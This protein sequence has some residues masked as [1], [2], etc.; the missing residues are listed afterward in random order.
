MTREVLAGLVGKS[1]SWLKAV[2]H[3][4]R[5]QNPRL[6]IL[7]QLAE[8]LRVRDLR[9]LTGDQ[10]LPV[11]M[12]TGSG[13]P[14]LSAVREAVNAV[15]IQ[16]SGTVQPLTTL[17]ARLD[18]A[19]RV[20][21][22]SPDHR[23]ALG[24]LLPD[25]IRDAQLA[26]GLCRG[27]Q[28]RAAQALLAEVYG[29]TQ[30]FVAYQPA[31]DLLW[32]V[33]DRALIAARES[34]DPLAL[35]C[36]VWFL[37]QA[38]REAADFDAA[39]EINRQGMAAIEPYMDDPSTEL[40]AMWGALSFELAFTAARTGDI[41]EAWRH[42]DEA[43]QV[44][45]RLPVGYYQPW[46]SFSQVIMKPHAVT[47]AVELRQGG[48]SARQSDHAESVPIP[49][50]PRRARHLVEVARA[51]LLQRDH[52]AVLGTLQ[53]AYQAAPETVRYNGYARRMILDLH[54]TG[55]APVR[56]PARELAGQIGL[57]L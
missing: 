5:Q 11:R 57:M 18:A 27:E 9:E 3:G 20:R 34:E 17:R 54:E 41:G 12:F 47:V 44:A 49:S 4:R 37:A 10:S 40:L 28:R 33:A 7:L 53:L 51:H 1:E 30:M 6:P 21:H 26:A 43:A 25:L 39:H 31:S 29:L 56:S 13:H 50:R 42:W 46:T 48:E 16:P 19:W 32:R 38:H 15:P 35:S 52:M 8:A 2:E 22:A 23:T 45:E 55:P 24:E 36:A 14:A